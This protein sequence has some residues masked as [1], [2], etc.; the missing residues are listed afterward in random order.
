MSELK[1]KIRKTGSSK[2][3]NRRLRNFRVR[4]NPVRSDKLNPA[5]LNLRSR[6]AV[7]VRQ[8]HNILAVK[9]PQRQRR[10][11]KLC[12]SK[13][14]YRRCGIR[15]D[16]KNAPAVKQLINIIMVKRVFRMSEN[17]VILKQRSH[18][19]SVSAN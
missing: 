6:P 18:N 15:S 1:L 11:G 2:Y 12:R 9:K 17:I 16:N 19:L 4:L 3:I 7:S 10:F 14:S 13:P 5:L 8:P